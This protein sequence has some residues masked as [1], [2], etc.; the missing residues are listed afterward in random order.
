MEWSRTGSKY[1]GRTKDRRM[2]GV[3]TYI[4]PTGSLYEGEFRD[5]EFHGTGTLTFAHGGKFVGEWRKGLAVEGRYVFADGLAMD[6]TRDPYCLPGQDRRF[7]TERLYGLKAAGRCQLTN[8]DPALE[9]PEGFYDHG[10]GF[11]DP[12][13]KHV[14]D[15]KDMKFLQTTGPDAQKWVKN[16]CRKGWDEV[17]GFNRKDYSQ[18]HTSDR[19]TWPPEKTGRVELPQEHSSSQRARIPDRAPEV[20]LTST[21]DSETQMM[22]AVSSVKPSGRHHRAASLCSASTSAESC[23]G[24]DAVRRAPSWFKGIK[25]EEDEEK[26]EEEG[27]G[28]NIEEEENQGRKGATEVVDGENINATETEKND[29][30]MMAIEDGDDGEARYRPSWLARI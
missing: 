16:C 8:A 30:L 24:F 27:E 9:I 15:Y 11:Y 20:R 14:V 28:R 5:G 1:D 18:K 13:L 19:S 26:E 10:K 6:D 2:H 12:D 4:F 22:R 29:N 23:D 3:G 7:Q 21:R 25:R 17:V